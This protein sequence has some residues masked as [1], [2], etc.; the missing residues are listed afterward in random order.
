MLAQSN[1]RP[2]ASIWFWPCR[3]GYI[4]GEAESVI[5]ITIEPAFVG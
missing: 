3:V 2:S 5:W 1:E 4:K